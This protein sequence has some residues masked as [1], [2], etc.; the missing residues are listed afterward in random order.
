MMA[1]KEG[2]NAAQKC[3]DAIGLDPESYRIGHTKARIYL[4]IIHI[5]YPVVFVWYLPQP[6]TCYGQ[7]AESRLNLD[8][9]DQPVQFCLVSFLQKLP[10]CDCPLVS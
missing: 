10:N 8:I 4:F 2:K 5:C 1:E 7:R 6:L 3:F 9:V